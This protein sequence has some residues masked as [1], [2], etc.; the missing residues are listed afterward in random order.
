MKESQC[1]REDRFV[2]SPL[3]QLRAHTCLASCTDVLYLCSGASS[4]SPQQK[5]AETVSCVFMP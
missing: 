4:L 5:P 3:F 2:E 1:D